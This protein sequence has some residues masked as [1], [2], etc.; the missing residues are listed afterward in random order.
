MMS[1]RWSSREE[2]GVSHFYCI[3]YSSAAST[4]FPILPE[5]DAYFANL[6]AAPTPGSHPQLPADPVQSHRGFRLD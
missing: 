4:Q 6:M 3:N 2:K 1:G 5:P